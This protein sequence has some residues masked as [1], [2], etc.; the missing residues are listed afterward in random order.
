LLLSASYVPHRIVPWWR[1]VSLLFA[2]KVDVVVEYDEEIRSPST[3]LKAPA[4][5]RLNRP[6]SAHKRGVAF[7]RMNV[8]QRDGFKCQYCGFRFEPAELNFD[9]VLPK[10]QGGRTSWDNIVSSCFPCNLRKGSR[11]PEEAHMRLLH[12]PYR[13]RVL[14]TRGLVLDMND[15]PPE[16]F[17]FVQSTPDL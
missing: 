1:A 15:P 10:V 16:W 9:H 13:P 4:V 5:V 17:G 11:T 12:V 3:S 14:P 8:F 2:G 6:V 7:T